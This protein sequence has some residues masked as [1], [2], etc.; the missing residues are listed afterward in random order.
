MAHICVVGGGVIGA[1]VAHYLTECSHEVT[2]LERGRLAHEASYGNAG[3]I[4]P[5]QCVP[6]ASPYALK[7]VKKW[8]FRKN[9]PVK[10]SLRPSPRLISWMVKFY[11][12]CKSE[13]FQ[14]NRNLLKTLGDRS[15]ELFKELDSQGIEF[16]FEKKGVLDAF[17]D[18]SNF[19]SAVVGAE[20]LRDEGF[21]MEV[22]D[23]EAAMDIEPSLSDSVVGGIFHPEDA[24]GNSL[25]FV[26]SL[27][28]RASSRGARI[29]EN[30]D[31]RGF[32]I[33]AGKVT[34]VNT[35]NHRVV[36]DTVVVAAGAWSPS[37][38][39][40]LGEDL[41]IQPGKGYTAILNAAGNRLNTA[42]GAA[43]MHIYATQ[44]LNGDIK[45]VS[46]LEFSGF[47]KAINQKRIDWM[48][49]QLS[50]ILPTIDQRSIKE[51]WSGLRPCMPDG[52]PA[53][54]KSSHYDNVY[55]AAGHCR[56]G[57]MLGPITGKLISEMVNDKETS[58][59]TDRM[60]PS[61][62]R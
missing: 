59:P 60:S 45:I 61:R 17:A 22:L 48:I 2:L 46:A 10:V 28:S 54:G 23:R 8:L 41:L 42:V 11:N 50:H 39:K 56:L 58:V 32:E 38:C 36:C 26:Q 27:A 3:L 49:E 31:V 29:I 21:Q 51:V 44:M 7:L 35:R 52:L 57:F 37:I 6:L 34:A 62:F 24:Q 1:S 14:E 43:D 13:E 20:E 16:E 9:S 4:V 33:D 55:V 53:I 40:I 47:D 19:T 12:A 30:A 18:E 25:L 5:S 15:L